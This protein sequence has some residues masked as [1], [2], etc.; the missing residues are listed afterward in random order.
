M[1]ISPTQANARSKTLMKIAPEFSLFMHYVFAP[2]R[3]TNHRGIYNPWLKSNALMFA[4]N[5]TMSPPYQVL[6]LDLAGCTYSNTN[7]VGVNS[8]TKFTVRQ[9]KVIPVHR[10][11]SRYST[12][13]SGSTPRA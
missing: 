11:M 5:L 9:V 10:I 12:S 8:T 4:L 6:A 13:E 2:L 1:A 3:K 7:A